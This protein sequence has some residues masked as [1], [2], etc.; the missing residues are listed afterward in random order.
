MIRRIWSRNPILSLAFV[1]AVAACLFFTG[2]ATLFAVNLYFRSEKPVAGWMTPRYIALAYGLD[3]ADLARIL[4]STRRDDAREP[5]YRIA[6]TADLPVADLIADVQAAV[7]AKG[8][9]Q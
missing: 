2:R 7:D 1:L 3:G 5:L 8:A 9:G 4:H 6:E